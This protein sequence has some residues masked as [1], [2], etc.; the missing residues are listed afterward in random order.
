MCVVKSLKALLQLFE[1][2]STKLDE[3]VGICNWEIN[4]Q[5]KT[6]EFAN[7]LVGVEIVNRPVETVITV[8]VDEKTG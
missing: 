2:L 5:C 8:V 7:I 3:M 1:Q 4:F 6:R